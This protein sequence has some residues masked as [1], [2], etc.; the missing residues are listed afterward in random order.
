VLSTMIA[1]LFSS[2]PPLPPPSSSSLKANATRT[3]RPERRQQRHPQTTTT[4]T[5]TPATSRAL[6][7][8]GK[9]STERQ[10]ASDLKKLGCDAG[11]AYLKKSGGGNNNSNDDGGGN[12]RSNGLSI[13]S[14]ALEI[15]DRILD[16]KTSGDDDDDDDENDGRPFGSKEYLQSVYDDVKEWIGDGRRA[17]EEEGKITDSPTPPRRRRRR[18]RGSSWTMSRPWR[19]CWETRWCTAS[20]KA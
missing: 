17:E 9:A 19:R 2:H 1:Q 6:W 13:R 7:L 8:S 15:A 20:W 12:R 4:T 16:G 5:T 18:C 11:A 14:L 3:K 10:V